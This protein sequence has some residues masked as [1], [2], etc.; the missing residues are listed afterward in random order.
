MSGRKSLG[1]LGIGSPGVG[2][3]AGVGGGRVSGGK[4]YLG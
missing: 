2:Y 4:G 3:L 1:Y